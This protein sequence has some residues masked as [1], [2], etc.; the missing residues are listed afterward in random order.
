VSVATPAGFVIATLPADSVPHAVNAGCPTVEKVT[1]SPPAG[2]PKV[3][4]TV[5]V[6]VLVVIPLPVR[7]RGVAATAIV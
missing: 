2:T 3:F 6:M 5:A 4:V 7:V 1:V